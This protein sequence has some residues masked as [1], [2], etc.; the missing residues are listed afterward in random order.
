MAELEPFESQ[1]RGF[2]NGDRI[3][4]KIPATREQELVRL[5]R[6]Q[7]P[8]VLRSLLQELMQAMASCAESLQYEASILPAEQMRQRVLPEQFI[9]KQ[10]MQ[11]RLDGGLEIDGSR[12]HLLPTTQEELP[13][14]HVLEHR[15]A[16]EERRPLLSVYS[17]VSLKVTSYE[18]Y[19][20][21]LGGTEL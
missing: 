16:Q 1:S 7:E 19:C 9:R 18:S 8:T 4:Y 15:K 10:Q 11:S 2:Q 14:H 12:R 20:P 3:V 21:N 17:Q 5:F 6:K 13:G